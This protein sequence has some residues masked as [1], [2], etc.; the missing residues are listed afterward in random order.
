MIVCKE[1]CE[2]VHQETTIGKTTFNLKCLSCGKVL[3]VGVPKD[4][5]EKWPVPPKKSTK[6]E[7]DLQ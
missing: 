4:L 1:K 3:G 6:K 2:I 7:N 5:H